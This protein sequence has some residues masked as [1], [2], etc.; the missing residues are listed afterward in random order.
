MRQPGLLFSFQAPT[1]RS[2][3]K[4]LTDSEIAAL[5]YRL[6]ENGQLALDNIAVFEFEYLMKDKPQGEYD[7]TMTSVLYGIESDPASV[8]TVNFIQPAAPRNFAVSWIES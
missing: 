1:Q 4:P 2:D 6:Y 7:F 8:P 3:G 5:H